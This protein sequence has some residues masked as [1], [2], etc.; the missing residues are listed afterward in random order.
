MS[1]EA[2][3]VAHDATWA[4]LGA[5][6]DDFRAAI[7][8]RRRVLRQEPFGSPA[9]LAARDGVAAAWR[10][11]GTCWQLHFGAPPPYRLPRD[12]ERR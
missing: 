7:A 9:S 2:E 6:L 3:A 4:A 5:A 8:Q 12:R 1:R 10:N 11:V